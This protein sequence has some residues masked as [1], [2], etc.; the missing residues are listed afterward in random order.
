M[1]LNPADPVARDGFTQIPNFI[2]RDPNKLDRRKNGLLAASQLRVA[3][4]PLFP[5]PGPPRQG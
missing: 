1:K 5:W 2:L 3:Q 4:R